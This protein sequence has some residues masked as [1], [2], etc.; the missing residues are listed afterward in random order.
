LSAARQVIIENLILNSPKKIE[1]E[2]ADMLAEAT[3]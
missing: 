1:K 3:E 2:I